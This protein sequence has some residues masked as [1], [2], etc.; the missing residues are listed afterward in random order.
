MRFDTRDKKPKIWNILILTVLVALSLYVMHLFKVSSV[1]ASTVVALYLLGVVLM[2]IDGIIRQLQYNPYSYNIIYYAGFVLFVQSIFVSCVVTTFYEMNQAGIASSHYYVGIVLSSA[3]IFMLL[4]LPFVLVFS[5][6][7]IITN[8]S[9][10]RHEGGSRVNVLG[11]LL[12]F[13]MLLGEAMV[14]NLGYEGAIDADENLTQ[15]ILG[16]LFAAIYLY[17]ECMLIGTMIANAIVVKH[18]PAPDKDFI[19]VLGCAIR[20]DGTPKPLL[21]GRL[22]RAIRFRERQLKETGKDVIFITSGGQGSDEVVPES[23]SMKQYLISKGIPAD[24]I[25][26]E[27]LSTNTMENMRYSRQKIIEHLNASGTVVDEDISNA[28]ILFCTTNYH[29]FRSGA[30]ARYANMRAVG[31]GAPTKWYFWPNAAVREFVGLL[32]AHRGKQI[33]VF[34]GLILFYTV[35]TIVSSI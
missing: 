23:T 20:N 1:T 28:N 15:E 27:S 6:L 7:M 11:I 35:F 19:I 13:F 25:I 26:E 33:L 18:K 30:Y 29:V 12:A 21:R 31:I 16:N 24:R 3:R 2:L 8:V 22:D 5:V 34:G 9:L 32:T 10:I 17:F 4:S 14:F